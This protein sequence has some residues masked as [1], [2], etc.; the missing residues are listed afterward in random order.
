MKKLK[1]EKE[2]EIEKSDVNEICVRTAA[3]C[4]V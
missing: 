2:G 4:G 3:Q 1:L